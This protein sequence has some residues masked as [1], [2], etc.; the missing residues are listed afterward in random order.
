M[1]L[2][3][4]VGDNHFVS[5]L[6]MSAFMPRVRMVTSVEP[7]PAIKSARLHS[8]DVIGRQIVAEFVPLVSAHPQF[9]GF[10]SKG[11]S[12]RITNSPGEYFFTGTVRVQLKY[13][14]A[15]F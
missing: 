3:Q 6:G 8:A 13:P 9:I 5:E 10:G 4:H 2:D 11:D 7:W 15:V 14:S 1:R 12:D